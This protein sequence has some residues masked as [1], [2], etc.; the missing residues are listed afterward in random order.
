MFEFNE[1]KSK[2]NKIKHGIDFKSAVRLWNDQC[3]LE[4]PARNIDEERFMLIAMLDSDC[5]SAI[6]TKRNKNI[7]IVSVRKSREYEKAIHNKF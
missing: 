7:R 2:A 3:R 6:F 4:I 5:W 1:K